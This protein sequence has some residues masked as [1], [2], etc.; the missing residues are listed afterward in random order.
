MI[1]GLCVS[2]FLFFLALGNFL[3]T[4]L[5]KLA[6]QA[7]LRILVCALACAKQSSRTLKMIYKTVSNCKCACFQR[8]LSFDFINIDIKSPMPTTTST[9][10]H[11]CLPSAILKNG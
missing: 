10:F 4:I 2:V 6:K 3:K 5:S 1:V 11:I 7:L 9:M 8:G